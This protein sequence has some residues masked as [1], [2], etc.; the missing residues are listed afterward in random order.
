MKSRIKS[1]RG[2]GTYYELEDEINVFCRR[3]NCNPISV[4]VIYSAGTYVAFV[5]VEEGEKDDR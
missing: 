4:S 1:F 5:V 3:H 2:N